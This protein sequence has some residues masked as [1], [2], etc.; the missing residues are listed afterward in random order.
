MFLKE[1]RS[2]QKDNNTFQLSYGSGA[3]V[4]GTSFF[5]QA[6]ER[7]DNVYISWLCG[8]EGV[9]CVC[10]CLS[11]CL[12]VCVFCTYKLLKAWSSKKL[13]KLTPKYSCFDGSEIST[14][15]HLKILTICNIH[16]K[17]FSFFFSFCN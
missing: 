12:S 17:S 11:V 8:L 4:R 7:I 5:F 6:E 1:N 14:S 15:P 9:R 10:V 16:I 2:A 3:L 13:K